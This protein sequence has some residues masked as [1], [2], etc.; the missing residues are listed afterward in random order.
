M[1]NP[2]MESHTDLQAPIGL[3]PPQT[4]CA[5]KEPF[6]ETG[7]YYYGARYLDPKTSVWISADPAMGDYVPRAPSGDEARKHNR[8][9]PGMGGV[10]NY[11]NMHVYHYAGNNPIKYIDPDRRFV[12]DIME[13]TISCDLTD[14]DDMSKASILFGIDDTSTR[15][16]AFA[17]EKKVGEFYVEKLSESLV[18][19][20]YNTF[21]GDSVFK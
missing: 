19:F 6:S 4:R 16:I 13:G 15:C 8:N 9:L 21:L 7:F 20:V 12:P 14:V 2:A 11:V 5:F 1:R 18:G 10:Y 3:K 17:I